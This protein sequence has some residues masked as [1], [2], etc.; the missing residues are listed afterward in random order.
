MDRVSYLESSEVNSKNLNKI[1]RGL[2]KEK[3]LDRLPKNS[4]MILRFKDSFSYVKS[5]P[6]RTLSGVAPIT[7]V[8]APIACPEQAKCIYCP[9]GPNSAFGNTPKSYVDTAP[10]IRRA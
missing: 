9:G 10:A 8:T 4:E 7:I 1:K 2:M 5:K 6:I 3:N